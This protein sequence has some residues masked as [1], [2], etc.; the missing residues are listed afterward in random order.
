[1]AGGTAPDYYVHLGVDSSA[2]QDE[3]KSAY[4]ILAQLYHPDKNPESI[5]AERRFMAITEAYAVLH[6]PKKRVA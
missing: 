1:M 4:R 3:I 5:G 6:D 2:T